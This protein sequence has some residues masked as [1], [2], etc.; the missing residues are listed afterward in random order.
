[1]AN[2][3]YQRIAEEVDR[4]YRCD[5][6]V[7]RVKHRTNGDGRTVFVRQCERCG[8]NRG[9]VRKDSEL[10][11]AAKEAFDET[12][13]REWYTARQQY[14]TSLME[15]ARQQDRDQFLE[16]H[17]KY[18]ST[19][20]WREKRRRVLE[21]AHG[22]CE[23]CGQRDATIAHHLTYVRWQHEMLF[24]LVAVCEECHKKIHGEN[25]NGWP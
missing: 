5:H 18:L 21:R 8:S 4:Q 1:M 14:H 17:T 11:L 24:D 16:E 10:V 6:T 13:N 23:G 7:T 22:R 9:A 15:A 25:G 2:V 12:K 19:P 20:Q 3:L